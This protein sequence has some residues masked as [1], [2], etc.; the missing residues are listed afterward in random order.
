ME[1]L[2]TSE[3]QQ[4]YEINNFKKILSNIVQLV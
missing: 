1:N 4:V 2:E 3:Q